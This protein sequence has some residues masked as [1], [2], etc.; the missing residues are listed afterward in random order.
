MVHLRRDLKSHAEQPGRG[1]KN[2]W[3][4]SLQVYELSAFRRVDTA[5]AQVIPF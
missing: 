4:L 2:H 1:R 3:I 5:L